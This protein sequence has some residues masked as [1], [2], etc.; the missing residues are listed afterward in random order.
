MPG[1]FSPRRRLQRK[2]PVSDFSMHHG[3]CVTHVPWCMSRSLTAVAGKTFPA[4]PAHAHPRFDVSGKRSIK[5]MYGKLKSVL[6]FIH[7]WPRSHPQR[8]AIPHVMYS[9]IGYW[10]S[11]AQDKKQAR[12]RIQ[13]LCAI[14]FCFGP[15][16]IRCLDADIN[17]LKI[18]FYAIRPVV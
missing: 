1:T 11:S 17:N 16:H 5:V 12:A 8:Q 6:C 15:Y 4:F 3:T 10:T 9:L 13:T 7:G 18:I 2:P 14:P